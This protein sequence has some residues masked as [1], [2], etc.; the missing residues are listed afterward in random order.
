MSF[1]LLLLPAIGGYW[2]LT[3]LNY[4]RYRSVRDSGY[5]ILFSSAVA[6]VA[7]YSIAFSVSFILESL[8]T[9]ILDFWDDQLHVPEPYTFE[10]VLSF[11]LAFLLPFGLNKL[12]SSGSAAIKAARENGNHIELLI[13]ESVRNQKLVEISL[14][15]R[16]SYVGY[17]LASGVGNSL[18]ADVVLVPIWSGYRDRYTQKLNIFVK[19]DTLVEQVLEEDPKL[20][21][22]DFRIA[23]PMSEIISARL[24]IPEVYDRFQFAN[25]SIPEPEDEWDND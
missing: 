7:L 23:I 17:P 12:Y 6:G 3:H 1:G 10:I 21:K 18:Y 11:G 15:S 9:D 2:F 22:R 25:K 4:T 20:K 19:Y 13:A 16:K 14:R 24:F 5:H 8:W